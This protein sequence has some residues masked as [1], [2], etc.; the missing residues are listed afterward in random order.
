MCA[1]SVTKA[2]RSRPVVTE[3]R[4]KQPNTLQ[5][6]VAGNVIADLCD[7]EIAKLG[8]NLTQALILIAL[9]ELPNDQAGPTSIARHFGLKRPSI[10]SN[11]VVLEKRRQIRAMATAGKKPRF[12]LTA[13]GART[14]S[15]VDRAIGVV[16]QFIKNALP[17]KEYDFLDK[18]MPRIV[19][20]LRWKWVQS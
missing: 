4:Q 13:T 6:I 5:L 7:L 9:R 10:T 20:D 3:L 17:V 8:L 15:R 14:L 2:H 19:S 18:K 16:D 11:L 12:V 1:T